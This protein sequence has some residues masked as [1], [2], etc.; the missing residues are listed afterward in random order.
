MLGEC[1]TPP[2]PPDAPWLHSPAAVL[3]VSGAVPGA[4]LAAWLGAGVLPGTTVL[5]T[6]VAVVSDGVVEGSS[7]AAVGAGVVGKEAL[8]VPGDVLPRGVV[9][10]GPWW[11]LVP[12]VVLTPVKETREDVEGDI[13]FVLAPN[14]LT[15][16]VVLVPTDERMVVPAQL[17]VMAMSVEGEVLVV[18]PSPTGVPTACPVVPLACNV[19][20]LEGAGLL[21]SGIAVLA[22]KVSVT[23]GV[24]VPRLQGAMVAVVVESGVGSS[25]V[26]SGGV[27][28]V[29]R[30]GDMV[31]VTS[32]AVVPAKRWVSEA[33]E[34]WW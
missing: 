11:V 31:V 13:V 23:A 21:P 15:A 33:C 9:T 3:R 25:A 19:V 20:V 27:E 26:V 24:D 4:V 34:R 5:V 8:P 29:L 2:L 6:G 22:V 12:S 16:R 10:A 7:E 30:V 17:G 32:M 18:S 14:E 1:V 28:G